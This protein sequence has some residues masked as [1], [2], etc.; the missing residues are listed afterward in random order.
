[1]GIPYYFKYLIKTHPQ[2]IQKQAQIKKIDSLFIDSNSIIYDAVRDLTEKANGITDLTIIKQ[3]IFRIHDYIFRLKPQKMLF[4]SFDGVAPLSKMEQQRTRRHKGLFSPIQVSPPVESWNTNVITAG[5]SF[6]K[7]LSKSVLESFNNKETELGIEKIIVSTSEDAGEGEHKIFQYIRKHKT[8]DQDIFVYGL[9]ADLI[10]LSICH[11]QKN[12]ALANN[13]WVFREEPEFFYKPTDQTK[14]STNLLFLNIETLSGAILGEIGRDQNRIQDYLFIC[15]FLGNDFLPHFPS[16]NIRT[17]GMTQLLDVYRTTIS[18]KNQ[19]LINPATKKIEWAQVKKFI[20]QCSK[21]E[22]KWLLIEYETRDRMAKIVGNRINE[23]VAKKDLEIMA[24]NIPILFREEELYIS[25]SEP[26]WQSRYY[27][28]LFHNSLPTQTTCVIC[29]NFL[30]GLQWVF[31]YYTQD[32]PDWRWK[33]CYHYP[34]LWQDLHRYFKEPAPFPAKT[35]PLSQKTQLK[36]VLP[37]N[38][39]ADSFLE[40]YGHYHLPV[41]ARCEWKWTFCR[42]FW[43]ATP[44]L[45]EIPDTIVQEWED[46]NVLVK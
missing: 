18:S 34:P 43:E 28:V 44:L 3:V 21:H 11:C 32:C 7:L 15:F 10:M 16:M 35:K 30:E 40:K 45:P 39:Q 9:D 17:H 25:P 12:L 4:L 1:M 42:Y 6:M 22:H 36:Y 5:T 46:D 20:E 19:Y 13:I 2:I 26:Q 29:E 23:N 24:D 8:P 37:R 41:L 27:S 14:P 31:Q 33:Y 38:Y